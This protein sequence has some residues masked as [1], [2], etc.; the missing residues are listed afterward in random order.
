MIYENNI[1]E[2]TTF[3]SVYKNVVHIKDH[4]IFPYISVGVSNH[5]LNPSNKLMHIDKCYIVC[6]FAKIHTINSEIINEINDAEKLD[7]VVV[8]LGGVNLDKNI[9]T[10]MVIYCKKM[11]LQTLENSKIQ[12]GFWRTSD[13]NSTNATIVDETELKSFFYSLPENLKKM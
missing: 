13:F 1:D 12:E 4:I 8:Y 6:E 11:Y 5:D 3:E 2:I 10:E 9:Y 7:L